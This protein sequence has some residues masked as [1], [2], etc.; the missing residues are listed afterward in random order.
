[1]DVA[2]CNRRSRVGLI[3]GAAFLMAQTV[4]IAAPQSQDQQQPQSQSQTQSQSQ[5]QQ[6]PSPASSPTPAPNSQA[7]SGPIPQV[8]ELPVKRRKI[9]TNDDVI[10]TRTPADNYQLEKEAKEAAEKQAAA[11]EAAAKGTAKSEKEPAAEIKLPATQ[12]ET[13][14]KIRET[15][16]E[17]QEETV[18]RDKLQVELTDAS[19]DQQ[20]QKRAEID[21]VNRMIEASQK[22]LKALQDHQAALREKSQP[23]NP[24]APPASL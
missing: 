11:K 3:F 9:W 21:R 22:N 16:G 5:S 7:A 23:E 10:E 8:G 17:I 1:M 13:D 6:P 12:E 19:L 2:T 18:V 20:P 4:C 24:A 14:K 15:E